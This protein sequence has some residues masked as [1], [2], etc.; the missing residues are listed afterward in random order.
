MKKRHLKD[1]S[2]AECIDVVYTVKS[3]KRTY[4]DVAAQYHL[5]PTLVGRLVKN[6]EGQKNILSNKRRKE[7]IEWRTSDGLEVVVRRLLN[8]NQPIWNSGLI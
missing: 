1:L 8:A 2:A 7:D 4:K 5:S 6:F 3:D